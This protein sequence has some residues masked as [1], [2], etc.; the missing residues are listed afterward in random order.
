MRCRRPRPR[1]QRRNMIVMATGLGKGQPAAATVLTPFGWRRFGDLA[2]G[3]LVIGSQGQPV[4]VTGVYPRGRL[5]VY[6]VIFNDGTAIVVDGDHLWAVKSSEDMR[7]GKA[8]R[9]VETTKLATNLY[10]KSGRARW[11]IP[12]VQPIQFPASNLEIDPYLLGVLLGDGNLGHHAVTFCPGDTLV[13]AEVAKVLPSGVTMLSRDYPGKATTWAINAA[14]RGW[15][16]NPVRQALIGMGIMGKLSYEKFVPAQ[17]LFAPIED[18]LSLLQGLMDTDGECRPDGHVEFSSSSK[19]LADAVEFIVESLG[20][21]ARLNLKAVPIYTYNGEKRRG[22][23][24]YRITIALP[25]GFNPFRARAS[26]YKGRP[27]YFP[28]R[29]I[30]AIK[31]AGEAEIICISVDAPDQLYVTEHCI[32]THNTILFGKLTADTPGRT[33]ILAHRDELINQAVDKLI[34]VEPTLNIGVVK[35]ERDDRWAPVVVASVQTLARERRRERLFQTPNFSRVICDEAHHSIANSYRS[36]FEDAGCFR[37]DGPLLLGVTATPQRGDKVGLDAIFE[38]ICYDRDILWGIQNG[39]LCDLRG[40]QIYMDVDLDQVRTTA[41]DFQDGALGEAMEEADAPEIIAAAYYR[42]APG[43]KA[44]VFTPTVNVAK[45][46]AAALKKLGIAAEWVSGTTPEG[47]R[48]AMLKRFKSGATMVICN[49]AVLCLDEETEI[50]TDGGFVGIDDMTLDHRVANW[51]QGTVWFEKPEDLVRRPRESWENM[52]FLETERRSVRVTGGHRMLYRTTPNGTFHKEA[53]EFIAGRAVELPVSGVAEPKPVQVTQ[54]YV[55]DEREQ[56]RLVSA[57]AYNLRQKEGYGQSDSFVGARERMERRYALRRKE[58][59]ELSLAECHFIGFWLGDGS[60]NRLIRGGVEYTLSQSVVYPSIINWLDGVIDACGFDVKR[61]ARTGSVSHVRWSLPRGTGG[62]SQARAGVYGIEPYLNKQGTELLWGLNQDQFLALIQGLWMADGNHRQGQAMPKSFHIGGTF[63]RLYELLQAIAV[64]RGLSATIHKDGPPRKENHNQQWYLTITRQMTH[65]M[66][67]TDPAY[68]IQ[69]EQTPWRPERVWC[70]RTQSHNIIT[71]RRGTVTVMG[72]T[73]GFDEES[74]DCI[75]VARPT[76][77]A[78]FFIQMVGRG[79]RTFMNKLDCLVID[80]VGNTSRH[81]LVTLSTL[82]G[83][84]LS[85]LKDGTKSVTAALQEEEER[86]ARTHGIQFRARDVDLFGRAQFHW[87]RLPQ[88]WSLS[89]AGG[90][91]YYL[92]SLDPDADQWSLVAQ[93]QGHADNVILAGADLGYAQ[94]AAEDALRASG[95]TVLA[96][97]GAR[98]RKDPPSDKQLAM[99]QKFGVAV[100][101]QLTKGEASDLLEVHFASRR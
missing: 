72:N 71:R 32:V 59:A 88:G 19:A 94:G 48:R 46:T 18:R 20:G 57:N 28:I 69:K 2:V 70:V 65:H 26:D 39:Y 78:A 56:R 10:S 74:V 86:E 12:M 43:R 23:P 8:W 58:P 68:R 15:Y 13:P 100:P 92:T 96:D 83:K 82:F 84:P 66:G 45:L 9:T 22:R 4:M 81:K 87:V 14:S 27:H 79:T 31:P 76:K 21:T 36:V 50:L 54:D 42:E 62:G 93:K 75:I 5:P 101:D 97:P 38:G 51:D 91:R 99:L 90:M 37:P 7:D 64:T 47:E 73:E 67:G 98:W 17:Y 34:R 53:V 41:G 49:C 63:L 55:P 24:S 3:D 11:R 80:M 95:Q 6:R 60:V 35:A 25:D 89:G 30:H 52:Y 61:H 40:K 16:A 33:L 44:I 29:V 1:G 85:A 77:S